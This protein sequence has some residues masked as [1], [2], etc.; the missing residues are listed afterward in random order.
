MNNKV[1]WPTL[2]FLAVVVLAWALAGEARA[3]CGNNERE[4]GGRVLRLRLWQWKLQV[5]QFR[6]RA[7]C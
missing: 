6:L 2:G 4:E 7:E 5:L 3:V 1:Q